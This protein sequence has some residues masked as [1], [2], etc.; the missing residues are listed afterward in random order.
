MKR[1]RLLVLCGSI[2]L[3]SI[4]AA[5]PFMSACAEPEPAPAPAPAPT[6]S[7][8]PAP[9]PEPAEVIELKI[10][11][12]Q[13]PTHFMHIVMEE[14]AKK[15]E[16]QTNGQVKSTIYPVG[17][18]CPPP[19]T[20]EALVNGIMDVATAPDGYTPARFAA[21]MF[22]CESQTGVPSSAVS[23]R[24]RKELLEKF[25]IMLDEFKDSHVLWL[26]A[27]GP[28]NIHSNFP[29]HSLADLQGKTLRSPPGGATEIMKALGANPVA[30]PMD[31]TYISIEKGIVDGL[32]VND[33]VLK[34]WKLADVTSYTSVLHHYTGPFFCAVNL[35]SWNSLPANVQE[36]ITGLNDWAREEMIKGW[37]RVDQE[38]REYAEA[39]GHEFIEFTPEQ[40]AEIYETLK[41]VHAGW[42]AN[43]EEKGMPGNEILQELYRLVAEYSE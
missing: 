17:T 16:E 25:P 27:H 33:E 28:A 1:D 20:Y 10:G 15:L 22:I 30:M 21:Q 31:E 29:I 19:E 35:N 8:A 3:L 12:M 34:S 11:H 38:G 42:A 14:W 2:C 4:L 6:P 5:L 26:V 18:L 23:S 24:I 9:A 43:L 32:S 13:P 36:T 41:P 7:P 40:R 39:A 37:D